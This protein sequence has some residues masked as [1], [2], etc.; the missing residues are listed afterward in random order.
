MLMTAKNKD[1]RKQLPE[2]AIKR[3]ANKYNCSST[4]ISQQAA[5]KDGVKQNPEAMNDIHRL[6]VL[7]KKHRAACERIYNAQAS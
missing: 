6:I 1:L 3:L 7:E 5:Q 2:G 4:W